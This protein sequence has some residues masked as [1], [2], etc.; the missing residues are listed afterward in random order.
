[1][2][3]GERSGRPEPWFPREEG[4]LPSPVRDTSSVVEVEVSRRP[5]R[6]ARSGGVVNELFMVRMLLYRPFSEGRWV[7]CVGYKLIRRPFSSKYARA[8]ADNGLVPFA[9]YT[10]SKSRRWARQHLSVRIAIA[11]WVALALIGPLYV[12]LPGVDRGHVAVVLVCSAIALAW[13]AMTCLLPHDPRLMFLHTAGVLVALGVLSALVAATGGASSPLRA[14]VLVYLLYGTWFLPRRSVPIVA[15]SLLANLLPLIYDGGALAGTALGWTITLTATF[16]AAGWGVLVARSKLTKT[17]RIDAER[18]K[19]IVALH[20]EVAQAEFDVEE[21]V[22]RILE[23]ARTLLGASAASAG[24]LEG[25]EIVYKYRTGPGRDS[26]AAIR[27][28]RNASLSGICLTSGEPAHC[29]DSEIDPRVDK[30][31]CR[32]QG[33]RSMIIV[34]LR[35]RGEVVG[36]LNVNS[37]QARAFEDD[38]VRTVELIGG[39]ISAAYGHAVDLTTKQRLLDELEAT[40]A[41]LRDSEAKLSQQALHDPLTRLPNRTLLLDRLRVA[42]A[43][44]G[45]PQ[46]AVLFVD[47]DGFKV[48]NDNLGHQSGDALLVEAA[49]RIKG[50]LRVGD[51]AA[52]L[53]GDEFA[54]ICKAPSPLAAGVRVAKRLILALAAPFAIADRDAFVTASIGIAAH[55]GSP[56]DLLRD[57]DAAMYCAK[58]SGGGQYA[59]FEPEMQ[60]ASA[61]G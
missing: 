58:A 12:A 17:V 9:A 61:L 39:A 33:L 22:L 60:P 25:E 23:R 35:H 6:A 48:V 52:R 40:V 20:R 57:A 11:T 49:E 32:A 41:A 28:P 26:G 1:M 50:V 14:F 36:V 34:P 47:L 24:I 51:T 31:A 27:T 7:P 54:I 44:R 15:V 21:V 10:A 19:T 46:I 2:V 30:A 8:G 53:G 16:V 59:V 37:P 43:E 5:K 18:L 29:E 3:A 45:D 13:A 38:D 42:L 56:E 4:T 55:G